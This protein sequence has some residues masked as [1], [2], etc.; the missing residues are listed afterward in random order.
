MFGLFRKAGERFDDSELGQELQTVGKYGPSPDEMVDTGLLPRQQATLDTITKAEGTWDSDSGTR[1]YTRRFGD[2]PSEAGTLDTSK[3]HPRNV[4]RSAYGSNYH[5]NASGAYQF[6]DHSWED[7]NSGI[8]VP[9][10]PSNQ[11]NSALS[12]IDR[13]GY[14]T[15]APFSGQSHKLSGKWASIPNER[16]V[17]AYNQPVKSETEL[18]SFYDDRLGAHQDAR[19]REVYAMRGEEGS[20]FGE[21]KKLGSFNNDPEPTRMAGD[22]MEGL[23]GPVA[24]TKAPTPSE[25]VIQAPAAG[26][27]KFGDTNVVNGKR[28]AGK[29]WGWQSDESFSKVA[30]LYSN[31]TSP[32]TSQAPSVIAPPAPAIPAPAPQP[33]APNAFFQNMFS[34]VGGF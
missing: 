32:A 26:T 5:S 6:L 30:P 19:R 12:L 16:G 29:N 20:Q 24:P 21:M 3:P 4:R 27:P 18:S 10:T 1:D 14:D 15:N 31:L 9:M 8:N 13:T 7:E 23:I 28:Y 11:D 33:K 34:K 22:K 17:S 2:H 25:P